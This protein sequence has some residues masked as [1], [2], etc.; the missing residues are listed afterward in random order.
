MVNI[1]HFQVQY[2][3]DVS[4]GHSAL[5]VNPVPLV[6]GSV[7]RFKGPPNAK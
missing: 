6:R 7:S 2:P 3:G 4:I 5:T 1:R